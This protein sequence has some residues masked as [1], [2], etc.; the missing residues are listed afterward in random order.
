MKKALL[1]GAVLGMFMLSAV[2]RAE[3]VL[4][5]AEYGPDKGPRAQALHWF[6]DELA[7]RSD[8]RL[9]MQINFGGSLIKAKGV[10]K[11]VASGIGDLGTIV[12]VYTPTEL[13][14]FRVGDTPSGNDDTWV[15]V[16]AAYQLATENATVQAEFALGQRTTTLHVGF[17][18][19]LGAAPQVVGQHA[20]LGDDA[21]DDVLAEV[22]H[23]AAHLL[24]AAQLG[25][26]VVGIEQVDAHAGIGLVGAARHARRIGRL[27][28]EF[29]DGA[30]VVD[31]DHAE[32]GGLL[33]R[34]LHARHRGLDAG[35][36]VVAQHLA[37]VLLVDVVTGE[38][39][40][41]ARRVRFDDLQ[42]L[43]HR[44]GGAAVPA[45]RRRLLLGRPQLHEFVERARQEA[46][47][48]L[49]MVQQI[50]SGQAAMLGFINTFTFIAV[51][52]AVL[53][54]LVLLLRRIDEPVDLSAAGGH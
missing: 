26:Q 32:G 14:N 31:A 30:V 47:A 2:V 39:E 53:A 20:L 22:V 50:Y 45:F 8:G 16:R 35:F 1:T 7:K 17:C 34:H 15:G 38:H 21:R 9:K 37:V 11:G 33:A 28:Q 44:I 54:P 18:P 36:Q 51:S 52:F 24:V 13:L 6:A 4:R 29:G 10:L 49:H 27:F 19:P 23:A 25:N 5:F 46:P 42:V 40:D 12:G 3:T 43:E 41:V 48:A